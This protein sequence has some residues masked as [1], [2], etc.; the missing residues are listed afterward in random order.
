MQAQLHCPNCNTAIKSEDINISQVV[1]K[2][3]NCHTVFSFSEQLLQ[4]GRERPEVLLPDGMDALK[5]MSE[6]DIRFKWRK[7]MSGFLIFFTIFWNA[8][9]IP[10]TLV[11]LFTGAFEM[12]L[13]M[14]LHILIGVSML[15]YTIA[16]F[17]NTTYIIV[18]HGKISIEHR[19]LKIP[20]YPNREIPSRN[21]EQIYTYKYE[22][23]KTNGR[24]NYSFAVQAKLKNGSEVKLLKGLKN[25]N[26]AQYI[27]QEIE[28]F[29]RIKDMPVEEEYLGG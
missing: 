25:A 26:Q 28:R 6:L 9:V 14:S 11:A 19:P 12:L 17:V 23:S 5:L 20:F 1:A 16:V 10:M 7:S 18:D 4:S 15:Y 21:V 8:I 27:E 22:S 13:F 2:C 24:P 29:L 3:S